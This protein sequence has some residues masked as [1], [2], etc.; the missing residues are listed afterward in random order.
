VVSHPVYAKPELLA[1]APNQVWSWDIT[2]LQG[3]AKWVYY[4]RYVIWDIFSR[5]VVG[6]LVAEQESATLAKRL[7]EDTGR[8]QRIMPDPL[9]IH[10][11]RGSSMKSKLVA[12]LLADLG[13][14]KTHRRPSVS[15]DNPFSE[16]RFKTRKDRP[17]FPERLGG[18]QDARGFGVDFFGWYN[19]EQHHAGIG[20]YTPADVH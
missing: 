16:S 17:Q 4:H 1:T 14:T 20:F 10:A 15:Q 8:K 19:T 5:Y 11:D 6:W 9:T 7:I 13:V 18:L 2:K 12:E 3:P